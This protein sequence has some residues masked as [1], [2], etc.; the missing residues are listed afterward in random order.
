[1][2]GLS[3]N[4]NGGTNTLTLAANSTIRA[5]ALD[6]TSPNGEPGTQSLKLGSG[7]QILNANTIRMSAGSRDSALVNFNTAAGT[8]QIRGAAGG[9]TSA[10][11]TMLAATADF[12]PNGYTISTAA[13]LGMADQ[14]FAQWRPVLSG[15][16][17]L[18]ISIWSDPPRGARAAS[19]S[20][21]HSL[22]GT[23]RA[24]RSMARLWMAREMA[25]DQKRLRR[26]CR[27]HC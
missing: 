16:S 7:T 11:L 21:L 20:G 10:N 12:T 2:G 25:P 17:A 24:C 15:K 14:V 5:A 3:G 27:L 22:S 8:I 4:A 1:M 18:A 26:E 23:R 13:R 6:I 19:T 9:S